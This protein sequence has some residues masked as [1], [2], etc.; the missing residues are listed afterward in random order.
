MRTAVTIGIKH[1]ETEVMVSGRTVPIHEQVEAFRNLLGVNENPTFKE[2][3]YQESDGI[4]R[5][6]HFSKP[7]EKKA[8][9]PVVTVP[10]TKSKK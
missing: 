2:I 7:V 3:N 1:D 9:K 10:P 6:I 4:P 8:E 5:V